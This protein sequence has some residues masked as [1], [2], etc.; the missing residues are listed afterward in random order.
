MAKPRILLVAGHRS[1]RDG[2]SP[3]ER[4]FTDD[5]AKAYTKAFHEAG[6]EAYWW[7]QDLDRDSDATMTI[8]GLDTVALGCGRWLREHSAPLS[9]MLDLHFDGGTSVVHTIV[10]DA[11][12]LGTAYAGGAPANDTAANNTLDV[13]LAK[14]IS[15]A[16]SAELALPNYSSPRL[17]IPGV[18]SERDTGVGQNH[19]ARLA[20]FAATAGARNTAARLVI[21]H[22]GYNQTTAKTNWAARCAAASLKAVNA[23]MAERGGTGD[24]GGATEPIPAPDAYEPAIPIVALQKYVAAGAIVGTPPVVIPGDD[25]EYLFTPGTVKAIRPTQRRQKGEAESK[26]TGPDI[27]QD[28]TFPVAFLKKQP[29]GAWY[30]ITGWWTWVKAVDVVVVT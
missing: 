9:I 26:S 30:F 15:G 17:R 10:P 22:A 20:M 16:L 14:A 25:G 8:G 29:D 5:L 4:G 1:T 23:V 7:Q 28:Q 11:T 2:G 21:E 19:Q 18:M 24:G 6:Y 3:T 12:G 27:G 13:S